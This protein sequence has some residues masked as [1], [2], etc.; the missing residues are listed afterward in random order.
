MSTETHHALARQFFA[1]QDRLQGGPDPDLCTAGYTADIAGFPPMDRAGHEHFARMFYG[2]F[3]G[4]YHTV[5]GTI[6]EGDQVVVRFTLRG[7]HTGDFAGVPPTGR[8]VTISAVVTMRIADGRVAALQGVFD[9]LGLM[10]QL[11]VI[12]APEVA[13]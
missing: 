9:R 13:P 4:L 8:P 2:A 11:G 5:D 6:A 3:S 7:T 1:A 12:P 10:Q